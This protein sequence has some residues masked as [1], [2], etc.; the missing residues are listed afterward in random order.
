MF[1]IEHALSHLQKKII[2]FNIYLAEVKIL[3]RYKTII[4]KILKLQ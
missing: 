3:D 4:K 1:S 2:G